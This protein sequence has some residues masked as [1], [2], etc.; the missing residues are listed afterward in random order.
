[1]GLFCIGVNLIMLIANHIHSLFIDQRKQSAGFSGLLIV[2]YFSVGLLMLSAVLWFSPDCDIN[3]LLT[4]IEIHL[5]LG[6]GIYAFSIITRNNGSALLLSVLSLYAALLLDHPVTFYALQI[7]Y[8]LF[9]TLRLRT[10]SISNSTWPRLLA[11]IAILCGAGVFLGLIILVAAQKQCGFLFEKKMMYEAVNAD[12]LFHSSVVSMLRSCGQVSTGLHGCETEIVY[13]V[14]SHRFLAAI[15]S[16]HDISSLSLY[17]YIYFINI[18]PLVFVA[19][20]G[21]AEDVFPSRNVRTLFI[22]SIALCLLVGGLPYYPRLESLYVIDNYLVSQSYN[23]GLT[24]LLAAISCGF[25]RSLHLRVCGM[26][27]GVILATL[28]KISTGAVGVCI[29]LYTMWRNRSL[30][31]R[32]YYLFS[33]SIA[34]V[35]GWLILNM[36]AGNQNVHGSRIG[37]VLFH[38]LN[39]YLHL[40]NSLTS[41]AYFIFGHFIYS[42]MAILLCCTILLWRHSFSENYT[43]N[44]QNVLFFLVF[45]IGAVVIGFLAASFFDV[46]GAAFTYF[47]NI[48]MFIALPMI[49]VCIQYQTTVDNKIEGGC[50]KIIPSVLGAIMIVCSVSVLM[51]GVPIIKETICRLQE[52]AESNVAPNKRGKYL[53]TLLEIKE[54]AKN[55]RFL[56]YIPKKEKIFWKPNRQHQQFAGFYL[57]AISEVPAIFGLPYG[58]DRMHLYGL[59]D[60]PSQLYIESDKEMLSDSILLAETE[61][62][63][64]NGYVVVEHDRITWKKIRNNSVVMEN[65]VN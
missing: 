25:A 33:I 14:F 10:R 53:T 15:A 65:E 34:A 7:L 24:F 43:L 41:I 29:F 50:F 28:A 35:V 36:T 23:L 21:C 57:P 3:V 16:L 6:L 55:D 19:L 46:A 12:I 27:A 42:W 32:K 47:S 26:G 37:F 17:I 1:M 60:Y 59:G 45:N 31:G 9:I 56:V 30:L 13:H 22:R 51:Y 52:E 11:I 49:L 18:A 38:H 20:L 63:G 44:I 40:S 48:S 62:M 64:F 58:V 5:S 61:R 54:R 39:Y 4:A 8:L 2:L